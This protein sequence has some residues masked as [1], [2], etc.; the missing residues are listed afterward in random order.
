MDQG[1]L[2]TDDEIVAVSALGGTPWPVGLATVGDTAE[3]LR[4][5]ALRGVRSLTVR[6]LLTTRAGSTPCLPPDLEQA[7]AAFLQGNTRV[8][9][10]LARM[11]DPEVMAG[12]AITAAFH[13]SSWWTDMSTPDG[14]HAFRPTT[15]AEAR[16]AVE[17]FARGIQSGEL[18]KTAP[19]PSA[20]GCVIRWGTA[21]D[22]K[23]VLEANQDSD[24][25]FLQRLFAD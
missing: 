11:D 14:I 1:L 25:C 18:L 19:N 20:F 24:L 2:L 22:E 7:V 16:A 3:T 13:N 21:D 23:F 10:Y 6:G 5:A 15:G 9:A 4:A 12:A 8:G 17:H